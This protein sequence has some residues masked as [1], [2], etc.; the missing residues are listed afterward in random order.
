MR[1]IPFTLHW[2]QHCPVVPCAGGRGAVAYGVQEESRRATLS[3]NAKAEGM[4][5]VEKERGELRKRDLEAD[6]AHS[7]QATIVEPW[8]SGCT[9][10]RDV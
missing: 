7:R 2:L 5:H 3:L 1:S 4:W 8:R 10:I 9:R 6:S